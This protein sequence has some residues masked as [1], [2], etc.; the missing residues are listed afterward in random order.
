MDR[1]KNVERIVRVLA[2]IPYLLARVVETWRIYQ[3]DDSLTLL[4]WQYY[5][6]T[7]DVLKTLSDILLRR[8]QVESKDPNKSRSGLKHVAQKAVGTCKLQ[9]QSGRLAS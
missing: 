7:L 6:A 8:H 9:K 3:N 1:I 2:D 4:A 5:G